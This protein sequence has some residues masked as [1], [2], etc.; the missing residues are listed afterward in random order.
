M[1]ELL[2]SQL[3]IQSSHLVH[4]VVR[5]VKLQLDEIKPFRTAVVEIPPLHETGYEHKVSSLAEKLS[6]QGKQFAFVVQPSFCELHGRCQWI[7]KWNSLA[8]KPFMLQK[9]C[10]CK[11]HRD[12]PQCHFEVF[13]GTTTGNKYSPCGEL[14]T[15]SA[16]HDVR[17]RSL[18]STLRVLCLD[19][20]G[21]T[22]PSPS[23]EASLAPNSAD[24]LADSREKH[25]SRDKE[26]ETCFPTD[27]KERERERERNT[28][29]NNRKRQG[30]NM[31]CKRERNL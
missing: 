17:S 15:L 21:A 7:H 11:I 19:L 9:T 16:L 5:N 2:Q 23:G 24:Y 12:L 3:H 14:S 6:S 28:D 8:S 1:R 20:A 31:S 27:A 26:A 10:S 18:M 30:G 29:V 25:E 22:S 13:V 4:D